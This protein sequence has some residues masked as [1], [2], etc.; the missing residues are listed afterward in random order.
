MLVGSTYDLMV[1]RRRTWLGTL[2]LQDSDTEEEDVVAT[3]DIECI[4][5]LFC[6][7]GAHQRMLCLS[8]RGKHE[9]LI[10]GSN[11]LFRRI[12]W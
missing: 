3:S 10:A 5:G 12:A 9:A 7:R 1:G 4:L 2:E 11:H 8:D 6:S